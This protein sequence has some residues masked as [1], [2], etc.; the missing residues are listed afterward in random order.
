M[1][2]FAKREN[3]CG[4]CIPIGVYLCPEARSLGLTKSQLWV[5]G[6]NGFIS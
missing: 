1:M 6:F 5:F 2:I 4:G 3:N